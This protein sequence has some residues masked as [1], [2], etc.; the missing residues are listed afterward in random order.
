MQLRFEFL[1]PAFFVHNAYCSLELLSEETLNV[2]IATGVF[3][4]EAQ[5]SP[6]K[7][8]SM[9]YTKEDKKAVASYRTPYALHV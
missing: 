6:N 9:K 1:Y 7:E 8:M 2:S 3:Q 5:A 4:K